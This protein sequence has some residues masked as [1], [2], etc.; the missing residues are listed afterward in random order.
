M[1]KWLM[2]L[3]LKDCVK[4][5]SNMMVENGIALNDIITDIHNQGTF[6]KDLSLKQQS[7][8]SVAKGFG[9]LHGD[10]YFSMTHLDSPN[11]LLSTYTLSYKETNERIKNPGKSW[12]LVKFTKIVTF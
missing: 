5:I 3:E 2:E 4:L 9:I 6:L 11:G 10:S 1:L 8:T 12:S 7:I